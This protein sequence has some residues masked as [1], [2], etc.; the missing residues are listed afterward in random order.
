MFGG[1]A[2]GG[3]TDQRVGCFGQVWIFGWFDGIWL[4]RTPLLLHDWFRCFQH[5]RQ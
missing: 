1:R 2:Q 3:E 5:I 4:P